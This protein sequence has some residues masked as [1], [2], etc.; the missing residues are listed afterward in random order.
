M[1]GLT[2]SQFA[3][4]VHHLTVAKQYATASWV[5]ALYEYI[6]TFDRE[7]SSIWQ[8]KFSFATILWV[9][10]R[11]TLL[12]SYCPI[13]L[14]FFVRFTTEFPGTIQII[15]NIST[16]VTLSLRTYAL[17][18]RAKWVIA[19]L[20]PFLAIEVALESW[21]VAGGVP[22]P[23][24]GGLTGCILTG[25]AS[26][27]DRFAAFWIG[28][29]VFP[30]LIFLLTIIRAFSL[31]V[32]GTGSGGIL[33]TMLRDGTVYFLVIFFVNLA[34]VLTYV[35]SPP[36]IQAINA[37]FSALITAVMM[38]RL[39]LNLRRSPEVEGISVQY[40]ATASRF[41][42]H[43]IYIGNLGEDLDVQNVSHTGWETWL[44][45]KTAI[46]VDNSYELDSRSVGSTTIALKTSFGDAYSS[47]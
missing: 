28:Q 6:I 20:V 29:L 18:G 4:A 35:V 5:L 13:I 44:D 15:S 19:L 22:V 38:C 26:Q 14:A 37:P 27:G 3:T 10:N 8:R 21:A 31:R 46:A 23:V 34:N 11:Y 24:P 12:L 40:V 7:V 30:T 33:S 32:Q 16:G 25:K 9:M 17:Y 1:D 45:K 39:M 42:N 47:R 41:R 2:Q 43:S 36:D